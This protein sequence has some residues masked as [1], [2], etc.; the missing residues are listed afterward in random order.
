M[1]TIGKTKV[2]IKK[3]EV[4]NVGESLIKYCPLL[5]KHRNIKNVNK[6]VVRENIKYRI[7]DFG[8]FTEDRAIVQ[9]TFVGF[10]ASEIFMTAL[11]KKL[12]DAVVSVSDGAG[13][14]ITDNP[15]LV[16]GIGGRL[17]GLIRTSPIPIL[18]ERIEKAGGTILNGKTA[19]INQV[20]GVIKAV[21]MGYKRIGVTLMSVKD[22]VECKN[23]EK[24]KINI[25]TF[26]VHTT[27]TEEAE[28]ATRCFDL[29][30]ACASK[31]IRQAVDGKIKAQAGV[32]VPVF[33]MTQIG[34]ELI[35]ER[36]KEIDRPLLVSGEKLPLL[37]GSQPYPL[38]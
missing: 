34:K 2:V 32:Y 28:E 13:T 27:G 23:L 26:F 10:G 20:E 5:D 29:I 15:L 18:I 30:T 33:A 16:Q 3:G 25:I 38:V 12:L 17:S 8:L 21:K 37:K 19:E 36:A 9:E 22:A 35:L 11:R 6:E 4:V 7:N 14:V 24:D 1:E 31:S